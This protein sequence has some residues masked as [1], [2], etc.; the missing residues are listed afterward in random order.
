MPPVFLRPATERKGL[1]RDFLLKKQELS[2][3]VI[4]DL[5][6]SLKDNEMLKK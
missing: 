1:R 5:W 3:F 2:H 6:N 4:H